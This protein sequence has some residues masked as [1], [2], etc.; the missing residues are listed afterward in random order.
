MKNMVARQRGVTAIGW[1]I[2]LALIAFFVFLGLKLFPMFAEN[3]SVVSSLKSLEN[4][5]SITKQSNAE[6]IKK[7]ERRFQ[8]NDVK[9]ASRK[10]ITIS[11]AGGVLTINCQYEVVQKLG[12]PISV[13]AEFDESVEIIAH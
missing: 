10:N 6:I 8:I 9:N 12:G 3:L 1:L 5:P 2:I 4:E 13:L 7:I 11:R